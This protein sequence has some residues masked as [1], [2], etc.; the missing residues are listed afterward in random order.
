VPCGRLASIASGTT[1]FV[2][3]VT[4]DAGFA[5]KGLN[6]G[7]G[8]TVAISHSPDRRQIQSISYSNSGGALLKQTYSYGTSGANNGHVMGIT[9]AV[10]SGRNMTYAYDAL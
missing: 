10:D 5:P 7:N 4:Y 9:D 1:T 8:V 6:Y 3:G 2:S